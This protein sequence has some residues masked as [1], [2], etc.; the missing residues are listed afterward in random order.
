VVTG[1]VGTALA[2][3]VY[4]AMEFA[5]PGLVAATWDLPQLSGLLPLGIPIEDLAWYLYTAAAW[6]IYYKY[7]TGLRLAAPSPVR[8]AKGHVPAPV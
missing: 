6:G 5:F 8:L 2:L 4:L 1:V 3:P 7:A